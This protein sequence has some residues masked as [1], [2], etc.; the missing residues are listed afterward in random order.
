MK[1]ALTGGG[2]VLVDAA[3]FWWLSQWKWNKNGRGYAYRKSGKKGLLMHR[4]ILS[5][6]P[7]TETDHINRDKLDNRRCNLRAVTRSRNH[8]NR[9]LSARN[10]T[11][12]KGVFLD[13]QRGLWRATIRI[14]GKS[15]ELGRF[16][17]LNDAII[18]RQKAE[19][20][21]D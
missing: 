9:S 13:R 14:D 20:A 8:L 17:N 10:K 18:A 15:I 1:L 4:V 12:A 6:P 2:F 5:P 11:G 7:G 21:I 3:D 16:R 19:G